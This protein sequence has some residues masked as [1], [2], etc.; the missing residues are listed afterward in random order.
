MSEWR[1]CSMSASE[2]AERDASTTP[3]A[4]F[5][6]EPS[7]GA[8]HG[9]VCGVKQSVSPILGFDGAPVR[10]GQTHAAE[11]PFCLLTEPKPTRQNG[12]TSFA[13]FLSSPF[14]SFGCWPTDSIHLAYCVIPSSIP[15]SS[16]CSSPLFHSL[17]LQFT[18][19]PGSSAVCTALAPLSA[20]RFVCTTSKPIS[21]FHSTL[22][23]PH[24]L[25]SA[26]LEMSH[27]N[28]QPSGLATPPLVSPWPIQ[29][30]NKSSSASE[31]S[32]WKAVGSPPHRP[33][34]SPPDSRSKGVASA[35]GLTS[36]H[37]LLQQ[38]PPHSDGENGPGASLGVSETPRENADDTLTK[39]TFVHAPATAAASTS[40]LRLSQ[41]PQTLLEDL[42]QTPSTPSPKSLA[43]YSTSLSRFDSRFG[44]STPSFHGAS[45]S[46]ESSVIQSGQ[47]LAFGLDINT[48]NNSGQQ[49]RYSNSS[50][51]YGS[52]ESSEPSGLTTSAGSALESPL[53]M[54]SFIWNGRV[55]NEDGTSMTTSMATTIGGMTT[56]LRQEAA[57][58]DGQLFS[59]SAALNADPFVP[60][61][62]R[63][64]RS[65][66]L[67]EPI[68]FHTGFGNNKKL[69]SFGQEDGDALN[70]YRA[71]LPIMEEES[72]DAFDHARFNRN[73][74]YSTSATS[75]PGTYYRSL[76]SSTFVPPEPQDPFAPSSAAS[77][78]LGLSQT[79]EQHPFLRRKLSGG[80]TWPSVSQ[81]SPDHGRTVI[82]SNHRRSVTSSNYASPIWES[83]SPHLPLSQPVLEREGV[84]RMRVSRRFSVAP[85]SGFQAYDRFLESEQYGGS[86]ALSGY[87]RR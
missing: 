11:A 39:S 57:N 53:N 73:R 22:C 32:N 82:S 66:S 7:T 28:E 33:P 71:P 52:R 70:L 15:F 19:F 78:Y 12:R 51:H 24:S 87:N 38:P 8:L 65:M 6:V 72:E 63:P 23:V 80:P 55:A 3:R 84:E 29:T 49:R 74:S 45:T 13:P 26:S 61:H 1:Q 83:P 77:N 5:T 2:L 85:S 31:G 41:A 35:I 9:C 79:Q 30:S 64:T 37:E 44:D 81:T 47:S 86:F 58:A 21:L 75:G 67:S 27:K 18:S 50:F 36:S 59:M 43:G 42:L 48:H 20:V 14:L 54:S 40:N 68:G 17:S 34:L 25:R 62:N 10:L 76:S 46:A 60:V 69:G 4:S 56:A 16:S